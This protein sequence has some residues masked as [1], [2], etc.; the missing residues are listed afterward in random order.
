VDKIKA[1]LIILISSIILIGC[2]YVDVYIINSN[3]EVTAE[4][5]I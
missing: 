5:E 1:M 3:I 2:T 4:V